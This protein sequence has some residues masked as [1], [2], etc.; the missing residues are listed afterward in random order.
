MTYTL[1]LTGAKDGRKGWRVSLIAR[2]LVEARQRAVRY[3]DAEHREIAHATLHDERMNY[4]GLILTA[5]TGGHDF[6][7]WIPAYNGYVYFLG[8]DGIAG[9]RVM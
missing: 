9:G 5:G 1:V 4:L 7:R 6:Y 2:D 3:L 8:D